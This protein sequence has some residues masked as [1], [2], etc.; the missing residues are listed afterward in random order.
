[1]RSLEFLKFTT[2]PLALPL[3][4]SSGPHL[5]RSSS[6]AGHHAAPP[7]APACLFRPPRIA[8]ELGDRLSAPRWLS[9]S[10]TRCSAA[11]P[12]HLAVV[13]CRCSPL[14]QLY[15]RHLLLWQ[16]SRVASRT[17]AALVLRLWPSPA[18]ATPPASARAPPGRHVAPPI[19]SSCNCSPC[20]LLVLK[21]APG[22][23]STFFTPHAPAVAFFCSIAFTGPP[24]Q[25]LPATV[26]SSPRPFSS[27]TITS[28]SFVVLL[29]S[30]P[31]LQS[32]S[33]SSSLAFPTLADVLL[34]RHRHGHRQ[35]PLSRSR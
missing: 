18:R 7:E 15:W 33:L 13:G 32:T 10:V 2:Q 20:L 3:S 12:N 5:L 24:P 19:D 14:R 34:L 26:D 35:S 6:A 27:H 17:A 29:Q 31:T 16:L 8:S 11:R 23:S 4:S 25:P 1:V 22:C 28:S 9:P 21:H 30:S